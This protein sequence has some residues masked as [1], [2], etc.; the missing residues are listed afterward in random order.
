MTSFVY[1]LKLEDNCYYVGSTDDIDTRL[2]RHFSGKGAA[3]TQLH[4]PKK[5]VMVKRTSQK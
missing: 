3:W 2:Y 4:K 5:V 1:A